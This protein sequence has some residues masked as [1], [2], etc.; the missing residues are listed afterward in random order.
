MHPPRRR[1]GLPYC[2]GGPYCDHPLRGGGYCWPPCCGGG[3][4]ACG[5]ACGGGGCWGGCGAYAAAAG[6]YCAGC[7]GAGARRPPARRSVTLLLRRG[8]TL[9]L[10]TT[11]A[12][13]AALRTV[14]ADVRHL[15]QRARKL[16]AGLL[17][18]HERQHQPGDDHD[19]AGPV[20]EPATGVDAG[21]PRTSPRGRRTARGSRT[22]S[23]PRTGPRRSG[24]P[25]PAADVR[26]EQRHCHHRRTDHGE[27]HCEPTEEAVPGALPAPMPR[28][29]HQRRSRCT[30]RRRRRSTPAGRRPRMPQSS[31]LTDFGSKLRAAAS[32]AGS[33][34]RPGGGPQ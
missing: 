26:R 28:R 4:G 17:Q 8:V 12:G 3:G 10:A 22:G 20:A 25:A 1:E 16:S 15:A 29:R 13:Q 19:Q 6:G 18:T 27:Q 30:S 21:C 11:V 32:P 34:R 14:A 7:C 33:C 5:G 23:R 31:G 9:L 24:A 2:C